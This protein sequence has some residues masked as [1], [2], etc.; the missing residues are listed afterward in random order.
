MGKPKVVGFLEHAA[1]MSKLDVLLEYG[2]V[3][4]DFDVFF[5]RGQRIKD[6]LQRHKSITCYGDK[7]GYNIGYVDSDLKKEAI[8]SIIDMQR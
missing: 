3:A 1:D 5:V 8:S 7:D 6:A 4:V 2:G